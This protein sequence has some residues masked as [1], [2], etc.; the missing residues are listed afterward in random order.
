MDYPA[1]TTRDVRMP[2]GSHI[3]LQKLA[4]DY[5]PTSR[6]GA[7]QVLHEARLG[8]KL[9]TGLLYVHPDSRPHDEELNLVETPLARLPLDVVRPPREVLA[10]IMDQLQTGRG[11]EAAGGGG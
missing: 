8:Q 9:V 3:V 7:F 6:D 1:G 5:D 11:I 10:G 2:D 4:D